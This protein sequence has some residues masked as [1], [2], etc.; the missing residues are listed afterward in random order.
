[1]NKSQW[2]RKLHFNNKIVTWHGHLNTFRKSYISSNISGSDEALILIN[3]FQN[4][5]FYLRSVTSNE[6]LLSTTFR[7][8]KDINVSFEVLVKTQ[9]SWL[10]NN[11][12]YRKYSTK[13]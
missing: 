10:A 6:R 2:E 7:V 13:A 5:I 12:S 1:L 11:L 3:T 9:S 8:L 4:Y